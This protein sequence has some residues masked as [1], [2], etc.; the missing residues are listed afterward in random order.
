MDTWNPDQYHRFRDERSAPFF[1]LL[2]LVEPSPAPRVVDL[3]CGTGELTAQAHATLGARDTVGVDNSPAMLAEA[4]QLHVDGLSFRDGD[5]AQFADPD[6]VDVIISNAALQWVPGHAEV[7][8]R[9][10]D[11]LAEN[12][13]LA[14]QMP[15]NADHPS[16][17]VAREVAEEE[18]FA[19]AF[20]RAVDGGV[21]PDPVRQ[22]VMAPEY[23]SRLLDD[24]G[25]ARQ[26][27]RIQVYPH[28]LASTAEVVEWVKGTSLTRFER[29]LPP[30]LYAEFVD[31]YRARL[32]EVLGDH[33]P[34]LYT[35]KR[36]L[37]W[38]R[39]T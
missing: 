35:F 5:L 3:G 19:G 39:K 17:A 32:I 11:A 13:Q 24:L 2:A 4:R 15:T 21:P 23:Y 28:R 6:G 8:T 29:G 38:A 12:G 27:V 33:A 7:L 37:F 36:I 14:V 34:Y 31:R 1:D 16:H 9:W 25:F 18:P 20:A 10:R 22:N 30:D 26:H